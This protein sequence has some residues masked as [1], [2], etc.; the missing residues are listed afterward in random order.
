MTEKNLKSDIKSKK[1]TTKKE[2]P[3]EAAKIVV[4]SEAKYLRVSPRKL[5]L[6]VKAIK[7][8]S[9]TESLKKLKFLNKKEGKFLSKAIKTAIADAQNNFNLKTD[10]LIFKNILVQ[11]GP[12]LK[13]MDKSHGAR[14]NRG[15]IQ[16]R[17]SHLV[18]ELE[19]VKNN[20]AK[21]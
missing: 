20:G 4:K 10:S 13:R 14:F 15:I 7:N 11:E 12:K 17:M 21:S 16:K 5:R 19:G 9:V 1:I 8:L 2:S 3:K 6:V 18:V